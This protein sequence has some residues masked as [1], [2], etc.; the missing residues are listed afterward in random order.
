VSCKED[1]PNPILSR[2]EARTRS[3]SHTFRPNYLSFSGTYQC[4]LTCAHCC[5]PIEWK[6]TLDIEVAKRF[7]TECAELGIKTMG[8]TG[9]EPFIYP[10][11]LEKVSRHAA[12]LGFRFDK[13][14]TNGAWWKTVDELETTLK[15][16]LRAGY[17]G[18]L[19]LSI[20]RFHPVK[21]D[22]LAQFARSAAK[23]S[24]RDDILTISY[25][26]GAPDAGLEKVQAVAKT[27]GGFVEFSPALG[28]WMLVAPDVSA[29]LNFNHLA[30]VER[31][32]GLTD[33]WDG[34]WFKEDYCEGPGQAFVV[35]PRGEVKPCC[36]FASDLDQ[37]TIGNIHEH[38]AKEIL[39]RGRA[40]PYVGK[41]FSKGLS[42]IKEEI[43]AENPEALPG[44]TTNHCYF[45]WFALTRGL[46]K[47]MPGHGG[48]V[49]NWVGTQ[50]SGAA[51]R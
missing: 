9:G 18:R 37:L 3:R 47:D 45:C 48:Q 21:I 44:K 15:R 16:L 24:K 33:N 2:G 30:A 5:V 23:V 49:G 35:T 25:A 13:I 12:K 34:A 20:D 36:G 22:V 29:T 32:E 19:G 50:P 10:E 4:N 39:K 8:F 28:A 11:F 14:S 43:L 27:L 17:S 41:V 1:A 40:H 26:S 6:D 51:A 42:A 38:S 7:T 31:A 46:A